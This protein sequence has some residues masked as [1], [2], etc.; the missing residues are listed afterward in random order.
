[1]SVN[2]LGD[3]MGNEPLTV[4][5]GFLGPDFCLTLLLEAW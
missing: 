4:V 3:P 1:M 5:S 2:D